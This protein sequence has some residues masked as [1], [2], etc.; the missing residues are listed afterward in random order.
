MPDAEGCFSIDCQAL[1]PGSAAELR[2][3]YLQANGVPSGNLSATPFRYPYVVAND[4][5]ANITTARTMLLF[6]PLLEAVNAK[7]SDAARQFLAAPAVVADARLRQLA[8][9]LIATL[10]PKLIAPADVPPATRTVPLS[11]LKAMREETGYGAPLRDRLPEPGGMLIAGGKI[12]AHGFYAHAVATHEWQLDGTWK[13][14]SGVAGI[15]DL[16]DGSVGAVIE[17]DG[18][19]LWQSTTLKQGHTTAAF[20][21][22]LEGVKHLVLKMTDAGD[23]K[24]SDWGV[25][26]EPVI[27]R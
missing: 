26:L 24:S 5:T 6:A 3:V 25:W 15:A 16:K 8:Q 2:I 23:G 22:K 11:D 17:G 7:K 18:K 19:V 21:A 14:L 12:Y 27:S 4:G 13:N 1:K 10:N 9:R 20:D